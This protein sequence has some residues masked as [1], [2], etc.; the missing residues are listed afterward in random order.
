MPL[1]G[2]VQRMRLLVAAAVAYAAVFVL[3]FAVSDPRQAMTVLYVVPIVITALAGGIRGGVAGACL[4]TALFGIWIAVDDVDVEIGGWIARLIAF[5]VVGGLVGR[6][7]DLARTLVRRRVEEQAA[8]EVHDG[9]VQSLVL[10]TYA[11]REGDSPAAQAAVEDAL[12]S[13]KLIISTRLTEVEPGDLRL[14]SRAPD[15]PGA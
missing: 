7:E 2:S 10:A 13:A 6:Y 5:F 4:A 11:L 9:V 1:T 15:P 8:N 12:S 14:P 3:A